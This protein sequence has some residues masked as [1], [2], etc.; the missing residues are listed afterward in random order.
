MAEN[1]LRKFRESKGL[2][3]LQLSMKTGIAPNIICNIENGRI[4]AYKGWIKRLSD[5]LEIP[6]GELFPENQG[7]TKGA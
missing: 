6:E 2:S 5:A 4:V 1:M 3:Q 7:A